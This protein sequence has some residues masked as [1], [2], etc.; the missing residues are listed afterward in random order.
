MSLAGRDTQ[1][2]GGLVSSLLSRKGS[3]YVRVVSHG[4]S[5]FKSGSHPRSSFPERWIGLMGKRERVAMSQKLIG[6]MFGLEMPLPPE[7]V[8][9]NVPPRFFS[10]PHIKLATARAAFRLLEASL[11]PKTIWLPSYLCK[12]VRDAFCTACICFYEVDRNLQVASSDWLSRV[13]PNDMVVF[14]DYFGFNLWSDY[15]ARA[16]ERGAW[17]VEDACHALLNA[18]WSE[19]SHYVVVSPRKFVGVPDGGILLAQGGTGLPAGELQPVPLDWWIGS[20]TASVLR[21]E[22]DRYGGDR[23]W[24]ELFQQLDALAPP[25]AARMSELSQSLLSGRI[26]FEEIASRR[27]ENYLRLASCLS[28]LALLPELPSGVVPLGFAIRLANRDSVLRALFAAQIYPP[29]HWPLAGVVPD[30]FVQSHRLSNEIM[31]LPCDQRL[32]EPD[33]D[34]MISLVLQAQ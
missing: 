33:I 27:R 23:R 1:G 16:R 34:R 26:N 11:K 25:E 9:H 10:E 24:F 6:G 22:F 14:I 5:G 8:R 32:Q 18:A 3:D 4:D 2:V 31:T 21:G 12:V 7:R 15:G 17:I 19:C 30:E 13:M 29:V 28:D 20:L